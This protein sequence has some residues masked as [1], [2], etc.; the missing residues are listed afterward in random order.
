MPG[1]FSALELA[2]STT[3]AARRQRARARPR[4]PG[5][6][7]ARAAWARR[8]SGSGSSRSRAG[9][10]CRRGRSQRADVQRAPAG[11]RAPRPR[12]RARRGHAREPRRSR[13]RVDPLAR[14]RRPE[15]GGRRLGR[16]AGR[17]AAGRVTSTASGSTAGT[18]WY[19]SHQHSAG[20]VERGL[21]GALVVE[22]RSS[23]VEPDIV[24]LAHSIG[25]HALL[26]AG[27]GQERRR[28]A[29]GTPVRLRLVNSADTL[30]RFAL[31]GAP[32]RVV[33]IDARDKPGGGLL[34]RRTIAVPAAA[35]T[36]SRSAC[37]TGP[38]AWRCATRTWARAR[39]GPRHRSSCAVRARLRPGDVRRAGRAP[40]RGAS[41]GPFAVDIGRAARLLR[42]RRPLR[43]AVDDQRQGLPATCRCSC[44]NDGETVEF[45]FANHSCIGHPMHLHGQH[46]LVFAR[47]GRRI[48]P[49]WS[50][51][52]EIHP[53]ER[54]DV[55]V[56][57][58]TP[59]CG[60]STATSF[61]TLRSG[62]S[63]T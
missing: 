22:P 25:G 48:T 9:S 46:L 43:L 50:D 1:S 33:A 52:L 40:C 35:A 42:G 18:Y 57:P 62:S 26:G 54:Y 6:G 10:G 56:S 30:R 14:R 20:E 53:G 41:T 28:V 7:A 5:L 61:R 37:P 60:C 15:R 8:T 21:Y 27:D 63:R 58:R 44:C 55:A 23:I 12:G 3:A 24:A 17:R 34:N 38:C 32:F 29:A 39:P 49:W 51:T 2:P 11:A 31:T 47:D 13:G 45:S 59:A 4:H 19:H 36:T 16:D